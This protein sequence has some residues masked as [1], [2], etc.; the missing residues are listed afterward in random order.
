MKTLGTSQ[1]DRAGCASRTSET[2]RTNGSYGTRQ[3]L[4]TYS[5]SKPNRSTCT[6][7]PSEPLKTLGTDGPYSTRQALQACSTSKPN[8][9][10]SADRSSDTLESLHA[11]NTLRTGRGYIDV[12]LSGMP[13]FVIFLAVQQDIRGER[14]ER[15]AKVAG[16]NRQPTLN[17]GCDVNRDIRS[18]GGYHKAT[19]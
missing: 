13:R 11:L 9:S 1:S 14:A 16:G 15:H 10:G 3:T 17:Q 2:L 6:G 7:K 4:Q 5:T 12:E 8:R 18:G 19:H